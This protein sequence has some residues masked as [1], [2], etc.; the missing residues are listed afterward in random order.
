VRL[1]G[2]DT[3]ALQE[4]AK[5]FQVNFRPG[6]RFSG[7]GGLQEYMRLS[8]VYY[9]TGQVE[10]GLVRLKHCLEQA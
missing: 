5:A 1:P 10:E 9:E 2:V 8:Y 4:K 7:R 6:V 3:A